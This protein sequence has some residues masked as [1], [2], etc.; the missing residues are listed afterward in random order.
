MNDYSVT[1]QDRIRAEA[2]RGQYLS[3]EANKMEQLQKLDNKVKIP[4]QIVSLVIGVFGTLIMGA[5]M[6]FI[7][8][9]SNMAAGL[10]LGI[11]GILLAVLAYPV[12]MSITHK[13]KQKYTQEILHLS[14]E[15]IAE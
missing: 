5:G 15:L 14:E 6:S 11:G 13:R 2:I 1:A 7:M 10:V 3:R 12:Y 8:V 4:G 9:W